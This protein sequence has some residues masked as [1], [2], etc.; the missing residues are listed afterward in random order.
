MHIEICMTGLVNENINIG[1]AVRQAMTGQGKNVA[2]L[3]AKTGYEESTLEQ[4]L[5]KAHIDLDLLLKIS[6]AL[7]TDFFAVYSQVLKM[8]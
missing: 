1:F 2:Y 6:V 5:Q 7:K 8:S 4:T 3:A